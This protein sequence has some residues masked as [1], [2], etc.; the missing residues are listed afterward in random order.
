[1]PG[2]GIAQLLAR[3]ALAAV[4]GRLRPKECQR[5]AVLSTVVLLAAMRAFRHAGSKSI[6]V[7]FVACALG[8]NAVGRALR[9]T[10]P[11]ITA[12]C[13]DSGAVADDDSAQRTWFQHTLVLTVLDCLLELNATMDVRGSNVR[14]QWNMVLGD[15]CKSRADAATVPS[16]AVPGAVAVEPPAVARRSAATAAAAASA[17]SC[18]TASSSCSAAAPVAQAT[19]VPVPVPAAVAVPVSKRFAFRR[20]TLPPQQQQPPQQVPPPQPHAIQPQDENTPA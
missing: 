1:M 5:L 6:I 8:R 15:G 20:L 10:F 12:G 13:E 14:L 7:A 17:S 11:S 18:S 16:A 19:A 9:R 2:P 3:V 4:K